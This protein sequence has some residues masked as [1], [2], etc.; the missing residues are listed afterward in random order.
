[1]IYD[2]IY[3]LKS[4]SSEQINNL[5]H[6]S[7]NYKYL[8]CIQYKGNIKVKNRNIIYIDTIDLIC[9]KYKCKYI[10]I[11]HNTFFLRKNINLMNVENEELPIKKN[12]L[13]IKKIKVLKINNIEIINSNYQGI[14]YKPEYL[15]KV[16]EFI[17]KENIKDV[18]KIVINSLYNYF[19]NN[20]FIMLNKNNF[21]NKTIKKKKLALCFFGIHYLESLNHWEGEKKRIDYRY[22][23]DNFKEKVIDYF[24]RDFDI[25]IF[26]CTNKS[27]Y[28]LDLLDVYKPVRHIVV[29]NQRDQ[30]FSKN[31]K[32]IKVLNCCMNYQEDNDI[33]YNNILLSRFDIFFEREFGNIDYKKLNIISTL[34]CDHFIC[35]NFYLFPHKY[36]M[37][38]YEIF[39]NN[40]TSVAHAYKCLFEKKMDINYMCD[41]KKEVNLLSFY[42]LHKF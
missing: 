39:M 28:L 11:L 22:Y 17:K 7:R 1:M 29:E 34:E 42:T 21:Y 25:D 15:K 30:I 4:S 14:L 16:R 10:L 37:S 38:F 24:N 9:E 13:L 20:K 36:L 31:N 23:I 35:D 26:I 18:N 6:N 19:S 5:I 8:I 41:E 12:I 3:S 27:E 32:V 33:V 40:R 2:I